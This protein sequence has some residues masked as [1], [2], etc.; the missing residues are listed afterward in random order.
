MELNEYRQK[1]GMTL[2]ELADHL[3]LPYNT[4][5]S[6]VYGRR[7]PTPVNIIKIEKAT[8]KKVGLRDFYDASPR[9][10]VP[11]GEGTEPKAG[12]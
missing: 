10:R 1:K 5:C 6:C 11:A 12:E 3:G 7:K 8:K 2:P 9:G 4:V